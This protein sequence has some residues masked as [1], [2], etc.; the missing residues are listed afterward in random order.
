MPGYGTYVTRRL[1]FR[2]ERD[3]VFKTARGTHFKEVH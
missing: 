3:I 1:Q 2:A